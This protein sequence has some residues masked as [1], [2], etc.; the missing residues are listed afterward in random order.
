M[1]SRGVV[2]Q[3]G[4]RA[5]VKKSERGGSGKLRF[6][7]EQTV[8]IV[9]ERIN[10]GPICLLVAEVD[11]SKSRIL[12]RNLLHQVNDLPVVITERAPKQKTKINQTKPQNESGPP[13][14][15]DSDEEQDG[16]N[17]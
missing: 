14:D 11:I 10:G 1:K 9:R 8:Y 3:P 6:Y 12:H 13:C 17:Y 2:L 15:S 7:W 5:L 4:N 16:E